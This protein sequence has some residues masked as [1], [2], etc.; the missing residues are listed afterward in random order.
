VATPKTDQETVCD[1][2][3]AYLASKLTAKLAE[4]DAEKND[5]ITLAPIEDG[6]YFFEWLGNAE[7][8]YP[9]FVLYGVGDPE[10]VS[11]SGQVVAQKFSMTVAIVVTD[12]GNDTNIIRRLLR[13]RRALKEIFESGWNAVRNSLKFEVTELAPYPFRLLGKETDDKIIGVKL[14]YVLA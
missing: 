11:R 4:I 9:A 10:A 6:A 13:Y 14:E 5:G 12:S 3:K 2:V 1:A 8:N 7:V